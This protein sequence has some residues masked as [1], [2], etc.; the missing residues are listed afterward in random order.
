MKE[1]GKVE[2]YRRALRRS[3]VLN[4]LKVSRSFK[5]DKGGPN[6]ALF[7]ANLAK[8]ARILQKLVI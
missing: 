1:T 6:F 2:N 5:C 3:S 7:M 8:K 4:N